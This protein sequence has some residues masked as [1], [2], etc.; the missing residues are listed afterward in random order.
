MCSGSL[1]QVIRFN[2]FGAKFQTTFCHL[3]FFLNTL[4]LEKKFIC[5]DPYEPSHLDLCCLQK[6]VI[7]ACGSERV[8]PFMPSGLCYLNSLDRPFS[9]LLA[10]FIIIIVFNTNA[11][12]CGVRSGST[13][14][15]RDPIMGL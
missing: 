6:P 5:I 10:C 14:F 13:L 7:I 2:Y 9:R 15:A 8:N 12:F 3:L 11:A 1:C 4:S